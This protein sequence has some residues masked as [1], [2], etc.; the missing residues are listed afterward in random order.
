VAHRFLVKMIPQ[1]ITRLPRCGTFCLPGMDCQL[2]YKDSQ[3]FVSF[4]GRGNQS[5][6]NNEVDFHADVENGEH[7]FA[8]EERARC[9]DHRPKP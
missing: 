7:S 3:F 8:V 6:E 5:I 2:R 1:Q 4:K 9:L